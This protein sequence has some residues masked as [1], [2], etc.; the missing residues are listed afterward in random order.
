MAMA[1]SNPSSVKPSS[2]RPRRL[3]PGVGLHPCMGL[4]PFAARRARTPKVPLALAKRIARGCKSCAQAQGC[5]L[6]GCRSN[7][8]AHM[9]EFPQYRGHRAQFRRQ[10]PADHQ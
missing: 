5:R 7:G 1:N 3:R 4:A 6:Q 9:R 10:D 2:C 8:S